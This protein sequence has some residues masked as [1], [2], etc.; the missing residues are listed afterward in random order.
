MVGCCSFLQHGLF[1]FSLGV[2]FVKVV[3]Y[4]Y[5]S[6][7]RAQWERVSKERGVESWVTLL[8][9][10]SCEGFLNSSTF[11]FLV[12]LTDWQNSGRLKPPAW[13]LPQSKLYC[14]AFLCFGQLQSFWLWDCKFV[15]KN[16]P[17]VVWVSPGIGTWPSGLCLLITG[18]EDVADCGLAY[19]SIR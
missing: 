4:I 10:H 14:N 12:Q 18:N 9:F 17:S 7:L 19:F 3:T 13:V 8:L 2:P 5:I 6:S 16:L 1:K 15:I 11:F